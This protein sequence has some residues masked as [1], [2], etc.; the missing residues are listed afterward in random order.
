MD[1][2]KTSAQVGQVKNR[3]MVYLNSNVLV[4]TL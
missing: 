3:N 2:K 4:T 1:A